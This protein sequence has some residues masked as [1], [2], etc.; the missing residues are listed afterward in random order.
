M[1]MRRLGRFSRT[2]G[3]NTLRTQPG[4]RYHSSARTMATLPRFGVVTLQFG[5]LMYFHYTNYVNTRYCRRH[6]LPY[7]VQGKGMERDRHPVWFKVKAALDHLP[8]FDYLL[9]LDAD[10]MFIDH[11]RHVEILLAHLGPDNVL[12]IGSDR[13]CADWGFDDSEANTGV[14][15][16]KNV[17]LA[18]RLLADWWNLPVDDPDVAFRWPVDQLGFNRHIFGSYR[19]HIAFVDY[20][21]LNGIDGDFIYHVMHEDEVSKTLLLEQRRDALVARYDWPVTLR[22]RDCGV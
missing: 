10:A 15:L 9:F 7:C 19:Q 1:R 13:A 6:G 12:L 4:A 8:N 11:E 21:I 3:H 14:F 20:R 17:P 2:T 5:E 22:Q 16:L 18:Q